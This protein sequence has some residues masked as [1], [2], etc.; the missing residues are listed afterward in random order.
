MLKKLFSLIDNKDVFIATHWDADG[1]S[2]AAMM[3]HL[4]KK[5]AKRVR[6]LSKGEAFFIENKDIPEDCDVVIITDIHPKSDIRK[7]MIYC[8]HH[9]IAEDGVLGKA[10]PGKYKNMAICCYDTS[11]QSSSLMV[12]EKFFYETDDPYFLFL[13]LIGFFGDGGKK[14]NIPPE[15]YIRAK[16]A[17]PELMREKN[18][19]FGNEGSYL[20]IERHVSAFNTGKRMHWHGTIPLEL[21]KSIDSLEPYL[22][23]IHPLAEQIQ[24]YRKQL[25]KLYDMKIQVNDLGLIQF[26]KIDCEYNI[27][28]V[29]C[30]RCMNDKPILILNSRNGN[31]IG[32]LRVPDELDFDAGV[33][34]NQFVG[35]I[36][37][38]VGGGHGKAGGLTF[39]KEH[40]YDFLKL[41][42]EI[43]KKDSI[44]LYCSKDLKKDAVID[45]FSS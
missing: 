32:S 33:F 36:D 12:W 1:I 10:D 40:Y 43:S 22:L 15:L 21:F 28:G 13:A 18:S 24:N 7:P 8:D 29:L 16:E 34:L 35:K 39:P 45:A 5:R 4:V 11:Y 44:E 31:I 2:S 37:G 30:A 17:L 9:P 3:Y 27:Q 42:K 38:L 20:E 25:G 19:M 26:S 41:L 14:E 23:N 6:T